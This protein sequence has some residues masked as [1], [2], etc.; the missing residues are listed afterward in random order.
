VSDAIDL[1]SHERALLHDG[2]V[3]VGIDEVGRGALAG[4]MAV[5]AVVLTSDQP[6]PAGLT[7]SKALTAKKREALV[8]PL[9]EWCA[10]YGIG[11]VSAAEIDEWGLRL[12]LA[13]AANR[14]VA[15]LGVT[16]TYAL[17]DGSFNILTA[18]LDIPL[19]ATPPPPLTYAT[20]PH[21][22][23]VKGDT[24]CAAIAAAAVLAKVARDEVMSELGVADDRFGWREN[25]GYGAKGHMDAIREFGP[26]EHHRRS[27]ALPQS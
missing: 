20:L 5:G 16:P 15:Q 8:A 10:S 24:K 26:T 11:W 18:P 17:I 9:Q 19:G 25:K 27:W 21:T 2:H 3:V 14:A 6:A 22:V 7:D 13:V 12:A 4:P 23:I 1:L